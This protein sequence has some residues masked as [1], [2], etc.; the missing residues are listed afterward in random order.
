MTI[1]SR[2]YEEQ[3]RR[4]LSKALTEHYE[5]KEKLRIIEGEQAKLVKEIASYE[6]ILESDIE[7]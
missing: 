3:T 6:I 4:L 2:S 5:L 1:K 7:L